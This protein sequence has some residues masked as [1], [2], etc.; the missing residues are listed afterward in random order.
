MNHWIIE[1]FSNI[2]QT[3]MVFDGVGKCP[4]L[5]GWKWITPA[6]VP[7][8]RSFGIETVDQEISGKNK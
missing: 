4:Q 5:S 2:F 3:D 6:A 1:L 7:L 8:E